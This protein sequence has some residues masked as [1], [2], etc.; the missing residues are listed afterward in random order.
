MEHRRVLPAAPDRDLGAYRA[1]G[2]GR[3]LD[4]ARAAGAD[5]VLGVLADAGLRGRGGAG[6]PTA[7]KWAAVAANTS[8]ELP[9]TVVVNGAEGE[10][11]T[12]K[13]RAILL[14]NPYAV[15]EGAAIAGAVLAADRVIVAVKAAF[16]DEVARL[17]AA[18]EEVQAAGWFEG[19][20][21]HVVEGPSAYLFGEETALLEVIEGRPPF[22]RLAP[23][24]RQG[25]DSLTGDDGWAGDTVFAEGGALTAAPPALVN[26]VE[27][28][29]NVPAIVAEGSDWF[30]SVGTDAS[31]GSMVFTV[32]GATEVAGVAELPLGLPVAEVLERVGGGPRRGRAWSFLLSGV[33]NPL[34]PVQRFDAPAS[35]EGLAG[36]G[37]GLGSAGF[38]VFDETTHPLAVAQ[39]VSRFLAVESC[40]QCTP[41][42][43]DGVAIAGA[44]AE[45][46][47]ADPR[48]EQLDEVHRRVATVADGARCALGRQHEA[49][50]G[51]LLAAFPHLAE[52][53]VEPG[54]DATPVPPVLV[55]P[56]ARIVDGVAELDRRQADKQPDWTH[57]AADSGQAPADRYP[58]TVP[59]PSP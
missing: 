25:A 42:K 4:A 47:G 56:I 3:G 26:N 13:D 30:R 6:F 35:F 39:G 52:A 11:G 19:A 41:C 40:G 43:Q 38:V 58:R 37:S 34:L 16:T 28:F 17:H 22:P 2:G 49:V 33:S 31:P 54:F 18:A 48:S 44:L 7:R 29:A 24:F 45:L 46:L 14:A 50:V 59:L 12:A 57:D 8:A 21:L 32:S 20:A 15:L 23:P 55:A 10:P 27:T 36:A 53:R 5:A 1:R 9:T 51:S